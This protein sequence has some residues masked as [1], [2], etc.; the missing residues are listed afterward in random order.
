MNHNNAA[1]R[2]E[3]PSLSPGIL[4]F[5]STLVVQLGGRICKPLYI[6]IVVFYSFR[7]AVE[8]KI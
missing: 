4:D 2:M 1:I 3:Q 7:D 6:F 5:V 8:G